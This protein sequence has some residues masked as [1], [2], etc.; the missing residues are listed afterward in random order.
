LA[1][2]R[3]L[4]TQ[5]RR[6]N[7]DAFDR[8]YRENAPRLHA[9][10]RQL[11]GSP[12]VAEDLMQE[13][14][15][16]IWNHPNGFQPE[17]GTLRGYLYGI[18]RNSAAEWWRYQTPRDAARDNHEGGGKA[19]TVS[20]VADAFARLPPDQRTLLWLCEVEG[21]SYAELAQA[22]EIPIGT[23]RSRLFAA[24][25]ALREIWQS[26]RRNPKEGA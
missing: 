9:F 24:R 25:E 26:K 22:L 16:R 11:V 15:T 21:Q 10:L 2:D 1:D 6:G 19:E 5:I 13:A 20:I 8:F 3:E 7:A 14:F 17:R 4:W 23:V 12:Q 18:G